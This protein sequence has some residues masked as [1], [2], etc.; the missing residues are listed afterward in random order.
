MVIRHGITAG[1]LLAAGWVAAAEPP[2]ARKSPFDD[3]KVA[4]A[5]KSAFAADPALA[6][7]NLFVSVLDGVVA[8]QGPVGDAGDIDRIKALTRAI[9]GV[10]G[11]KVDCHVLAGADP[12]TKAIAERLN[13][14]PVKPAEPTIA[15]PAGMPSV[16]VVPARSPSDDVVSRRPVDFPPL[17]A[18][19]VT[20][21]PYPTIPSPGVPLIPT[22]SNRPKGETV[23]RN[24]QSRPT[25]A[26]DDIAWALVDLRASE[27]RYQGL[28]ATVVEG[29]VTVAG[30]GDKAGFI[31]KARLLP[32]V[33][34]VQ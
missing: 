13:P 19:P 22:A 16:A 2:I 30:T 12:L 23:S 27:P 32:G 26:N 7:S 29:R 25:I 14:S 17:P 6:K 8:V 3:T 31:A 5:V 33:V 21:R 34:S 10:S 11:V 9:P 28:T 24:E 1:I 20:D 15:M 18:P 4:M